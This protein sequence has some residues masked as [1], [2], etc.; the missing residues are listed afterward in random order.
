[1]N[2]F[3]GLTK[4]KAPGFILLPEEGKF[5]A[6]K[7]KKRLKSDVPT[8]VVLISP[9]T[10]LLE[11]HPNYLFLKVLF[12]NLRNAKNIELFSIHLPTPMVLN[13]RFKSLFF[14]GSQTNLLT[15]TL[16]FENFICFLDKQAV[17]KAIQSLVNLVNLNINFFNCEAEISSNFLKGRTIKNMF[18]QLNTPK[19]IISFSRSTA[20]VE[21]LEI[22]CS[23][24]DSRKYLLSRCEKSSKSFSLSKFSDDPSIVD[25]MSLTEK[26][27]SLIHSN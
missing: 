27:F 24:Y 21:Y 19:D 26:L 15:L 11:S 18:L 10:I 16:V 2:R 6:K 25:S 14:L 23:S 13:L 17:W 3:L 4:K 1:M 8:R 22:L 9:E 5:I 20:K 7:L 12:K